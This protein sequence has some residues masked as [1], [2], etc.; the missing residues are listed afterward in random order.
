MDPPGDAAAGA[1][2]T[3]DVARPISARTLLSRASSGQASALVLDQTDSGSGSPGVGPFTYRHRRR[4]RPRPTRCRSPNPSAPGLQTSPGG[5]DPSRR[6]WLA[7]SINARTIP[8]SWVHAEQCCWSRRAPEGNFRDPLARRT[9]VLCGVMATLDWLWG[10]LAGAGATF[11]GTGLYERYRNRHSIDGA[12]IDLAREQLES[13]PYIARQL[14]RAE[15]YRDYIPEMGQLVTAEVRDKLA[16]A[17]D[18]V[19]TRV[20]DPSLTRSMLA[21]HAEISQARDAARDYDAAPKTSD[22][23]H[24]EDSPDTEQY[25]AFQRVHAHVMA[26]REATNE[27]LARIAELERNRSR[28]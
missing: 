25:A 6:P 27:S 2:Q 14:E 21:V 4:A 20:Q 17:A 7:S 11:A 13:I 28:R 26:A 15:D 5:N 8:A 16:R 19:Q 9:G 3:P 18:H 12:A 22:A 23:K 10:A 1:S 24:W